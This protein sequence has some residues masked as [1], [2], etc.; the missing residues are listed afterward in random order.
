[1][2]TAKGLF[3]N[4]TVTAPAAIYIQYTAII[5][6][7]IYKCIPWATAPRADGN[8]CVCLPAEP[9]LGNIDF[10]AAEFT[11]SANTYYV[12]IYIQS[13]VRVYI[14]IILA[15]TPTTVIVVPFQ[16]DCGE[17]VCV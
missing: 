2:Q 4:R 9:T 13:F 17:C 6:I 11:L 14:Y 1:M 12:Y 5:Y 3:V 16:T 8:Y 7:Y 10:A 15:E